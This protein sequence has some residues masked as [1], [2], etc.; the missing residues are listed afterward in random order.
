MFLRVLCFSFDFNVGIRIGTIGYPA[1]AHQ[2]LTVKS[3]TAIPLRQHRPRKVPGC[4]TDWLM[5]AMRIPSRS[6]SIEWYSLTKT[7]RGPG[8]KREV[9][10]VFFVNLCQTVSSSVFF[11]DFAN[12][13]FLEYGFCDYERQVIQKTILDINVV[14]SLYVE[15][16]Y[17]IF[18]SS[19]KKSKNND[20]ITL[21][22]DLPF[23]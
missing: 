13:F 1:N 9:S 3:Q 6:Q 16:C 7:D 4:S 20:D 10:Y 22:F 15:S 12:F 17:E 5:Y 8:S 14:E 19:Y 21:V 23:H 2:V 11:F 18:M